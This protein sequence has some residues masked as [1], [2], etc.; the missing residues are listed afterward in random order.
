MSTDT[1]FD[2]EATDVVDVN[3]NV[4]VEPAPPIG[5]QFSCRDPRCPEVPGGHGV[6]GLAGFISRGLAIDRATEH[7]KAIRACR[8]VIV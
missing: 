5:W 3:D 7:I 4:T 8:G 1:V 6:H 2:Q